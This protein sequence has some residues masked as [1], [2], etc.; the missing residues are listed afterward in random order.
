MNTF[1]KDHH[2]NNDIS[3]SSRNDNTMHEQYLWHVINV[4][5]NSE[6][7]FRTNLMNYADVYGIQRVYIP[8]ET[9][10]YWSN[11]KQI[12]ETKPIMNYIFVLCPPNILNNREI[13]NKINIRYSVIST[14]HER[15]IHKMEKDF[16]NL[17]TVIDSSISEGSRVRILRGSFTDLNGQVSK[18]DGEIAEVKV[19]VMEDCEPTSVIVPLCDLARQ[20]D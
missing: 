2:F 12:Q 6:L 10:K 3:E 11:Q 1:Y 19:W 17:E 4:A 7:K 8:M 18:I 5:K 20:T 13:K 16:A 15:E 9:I 14:I